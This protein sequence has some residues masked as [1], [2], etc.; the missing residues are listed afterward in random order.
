[1]A[2]GNVK[3]KRVEEIEALWLVNNLH[4]GPGINTIINCISFLCH[5]SAGEHNALTLSMSMTRQLKGFRALYDPRHWGIFLMNFCFIF[6][7]YRPR[8]HVIVYIKLGFP[9]DPESSLS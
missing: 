1:M 5:N 6:Y 7:D 3:Q 8:S 4:D 2:A 9:R